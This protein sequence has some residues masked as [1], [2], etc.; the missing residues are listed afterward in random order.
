MDEPRLKKRHIPSHKSV[1]Y[2]TH[3][4]SVMRSQL[5]SDIGFL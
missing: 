3:S 5:R 1:N 2:E 4:L